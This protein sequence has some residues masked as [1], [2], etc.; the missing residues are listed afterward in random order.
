MWDYISQR[1][2]FANMAKSK[3]RETPEKQQAR[4]L[5]MKR[6]PVQLRIPSAQGTLGSEVVTAQLV[7]ND[8]AAEGLKVF[9]SVQ[10]HPGTEIS[11]LLNFP[12]TFYAR[13]RVTQCYDAVLNPRVMHARP[14]RY[15]IWLEFVFERESDREFTR[16]VCTEIQLLLRDERVA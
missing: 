8:F 12:R 9:S 3:P 4:A 14:N 7:L 16:R 11:V 1:I 6:I 2:R 13:A 5:L 15:R 10:L